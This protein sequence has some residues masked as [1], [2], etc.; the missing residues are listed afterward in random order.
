[1]HTK[2]ICGASLVL[3][4]LTCQ[5]HAQQPEPTRSLPPFPLFAAEQDKQP[6][7]G[8]KQP[9][10]EKDKKDPEKKDQSQP[11]QTDIL[12]R[13]GDLNQVQPALFRP[14]MMGWIGPSYFAMQTIRVNAVQT[15]LPG[16]AIVTSHFNG[17]PFQSR[18][19]PYPGEPPVHVTQTRTFLVPI[20]TRGAF[21]I[22]DNESPIPQDRVF[23]TYNNFSSVTGPLGG[24]SSPVTTSQTV[25]RVVPN[26]NPPANGFNAVTT[27]TNTVVTTIPG[28]PS[29]TLNREV[30][31][32]EKTFFDGRASVEL[33]VPFLQQ[34]SSFN[35]FDQYDTGDLTVIGKYAFYLN[36]STGNVISG[37]VAV[38]APTGPAI[39]TI[40]GNFRDT[41]IQPFIGYLW[42]FDRFYFQAFHSVVVPSDARDI[43]VLFNDAGLGYWLYRSDS[44]RF[45]SAIVPNVEVHVATPFNHRGAADNSLFVPDITA[46]TAGVHLG[47]FRNGTLSLGATTPVTAPRIYGVEGFVQMNWRY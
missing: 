38:T 10:K 20:A 12:S 9:G 19:Q 37:G 28:A 39:A 34:P 46:V 15:M 1:M 43:T 29:V 6:D 2:T 36:R 35:G 25:T 47:I 8:K 40:D 27:A 44:N 18:P 32:F 7:Q 42:N 13:A 45:L 31:G 41:L 3:S 21:E 30:F 26:Q 24:L 23:V 11:T 16:T 22:G 33:R 5:L 14:N 17:V 4:L